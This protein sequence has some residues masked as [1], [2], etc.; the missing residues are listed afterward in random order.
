MPIQNIRKSVLLPYSRE[1]MFALI[2]RVEDY[3]AFLPWCGG[4]EVDRSAPDHVDARVQIDFKGIKQWF[5]TRNTNEP[6][7]RIGMRLR[8]GPFR[9]LQGGWKL[10]AL[11]EDACKVEFALDYEMRG[12]LLGKVL[13]PLFGHI[14][15]SLVDAFVAEANRRYG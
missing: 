9:S 2:E 15:G 10:S 3:P 14:A 1:K 12:G 4:V 7:E 13:A 8:E 11:R 6:P 5:A